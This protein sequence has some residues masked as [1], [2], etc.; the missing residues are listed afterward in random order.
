MTSV[1]GACL[2]VGF[3]AAVL[4]SCRRGA[5]DRPP[6]AN[7]AL[8]GEVAAR[9][10]VG[11]ESVVIPLSLVASV[12]EAQQ[13]SAR[14]AARHVIDDEIAASAARRRGLDRVAP[15]SWRLV[16]ARAGFHLDRLAREAKVAGPPTNEEVDILTERHWLEF[17]RPPA[18]RVIHAIVMRPKDP[19]KVERSRA[20]A[21]EIRKA[22]LGASDD[23][24]FEKAA[25]AVATDDLDTRVERLPA[26]TGEGWIT[27]GPGRMDEAFAKGAFAIPTLGGTSPVI[28]SSFGW[29]VIRL[30]ERIPEKMV[31]LEMRRI[32]LAT[33]VQTM[34]SRELME[35]RLKRLRATH[36]VEVSPAAE[37]L[38]RSVSH[39]SSKDEASRP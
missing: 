5:T 23:A 18:V 31:P 26:F 16:S 3:S 15:A 34:R 9:V 17:A 33:E 21:A 13:V 2:V 8:G 25:K 11:A 4:L 28:E 1:R 36:P 19:A 38:M 35:N 22:V 10:A 32:A 14:E 27:E 29:H 7:T 30:R 6:D 39:G 20:V 37:Q 24:E 12:A